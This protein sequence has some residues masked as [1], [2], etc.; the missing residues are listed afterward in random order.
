MREREKSSKFELY[1]AHIKVGGA[2]EEENMKIFYIPHTKISPKGQMETNRTRALRRQPYKR[3]GS[4]Q[5]QH[6]TYTIYITY[7]LS[8]LHQSFFII[9][10]Y[11]RSRSVLYVSMYNVYMG[12]CG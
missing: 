12:R 11:T 9:A 8:M 2:R 7:F 4:Q 3:Y 1:K 6:T 10:S 5:Q